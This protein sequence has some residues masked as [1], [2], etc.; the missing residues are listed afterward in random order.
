MKSPELA[1]SLGGFPANSIKDG[2]DSSNVVTYRRRS[3]GLVP[4]SFSA[5]L[6]L[7]LL[8]A[9]LA[10]AMLAVSLDRFAPLVRA[11]GDFHGS[12]MAK[13]GGLPGGAGQL[14]I[15]QSE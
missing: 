9:F 6:L 11:V 15:R 2:E 14:E 3:L 4:W 8:P 12:N 10:L 1:F 13:A 5:H 7:L